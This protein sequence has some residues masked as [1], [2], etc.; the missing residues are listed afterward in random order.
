MAVS[1]MDPQRVRL[2]LDRILT[3]AAFAGAERA[4]R[5]LRYVVERKLE[6]RSS[7]IKESVIAVEVLS[8]NPSFDSRSDPIVRVEAGRL[9]DRLSSYYES[10][11]NADGVVITIPKGGY[12]PEFAD[13]TPPAA[14]TGPAILRFSILPPHNASFESFAISPD[15]RQLAFTAFLDGQLMLWVRP[16]ESLD[17][18]PLAGTQGASHPFWSPD[19]KSIGF[20]HAPDKMRAVEIAGGPARDIAEITLGRGGAWSSENTIVFCPRPG[21]IL[22]RVDAAGGTPEPVTSLDP[23]R[24]EATHGFPHF[25]PDG[26]HFLYLAGS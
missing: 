7:E 12:V 16:L 24:A 19:S 8:R 22:Y 3:S 20:F 6:G 21:E 25:L 11:G 14:P 10:H 2:Q 23:E 5:F 18:R 26:R 9:R 13:R 17:A 4:G 15:G 1:V